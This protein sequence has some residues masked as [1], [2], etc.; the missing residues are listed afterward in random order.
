MERQDAGEELPDETARITTIHIEQKHH[1]DAS[2]PVVWE[3][4]TQR[5]NDWWQH[6][7]RIYEGSAHVQLELRPLGPLV[8][9]WNDNGFAMW[10]HVSHVD[11]GSVLELTG[12]CGMGAAVH[13]VFSFH[14]EDNQ[15]GVDVTLVHDAM[16]VIRRDI[17]ETFE[18]GWNSM[19]ATLKGLAEGELRYGANARSI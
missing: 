18:Q 17:R 13:G 7:L 1:I 9:V 5:I 14:L 3:L 4:L 11:P 6:P 12:P 15:G 19:M 16:G 8:E 10:G 2:R